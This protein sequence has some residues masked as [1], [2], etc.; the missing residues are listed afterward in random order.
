MDR[1]TL[2]RKKAFE[3]KG[4]DGFLVANDANM[5]Y[6]AGFPGAACLLMLGDDE[7]ILYVYGVNY[8]QAK[9]EGKGFHVE[10]V[11]RDENLMAKVAAR[12]KDCGV[13]KLAFDNLTVENYRALTKDL[14]GKAKLKPQGKLVWE[15]RK[16]K[17]AN[18]IEFMRKAGELTCEGMK[19]AQEVIRPGLREY[20][21]AA[22]IEYAM[23]RKGSWGTAFDT[24]VV[25]GARSAFPHGG[26]T[27]KEIREGDLVV[28]DIGASY[29][30]YRSDM[31]RT[32]VAGKPSEKQEKLYKIVE[33]AQQRATQIV[34][35]KA[36]ARYVDALA[37]KIIEEAGYGENFVHS[38]GHGI[39]LEVH[40][41]P[42]LSQQS[43]D[44]LAAGNVV[45]IEPGIYIVG[46]GGIRIEDTMLVKEEGVEKFTDGFYTI[47][48]GR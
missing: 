16:V 35:A 38:L 10:L 46:F 11:K 3:A 48:A 42:A 30:Y 9:A 7:N 29:H 43:R 44:R 5:L 25:S 4:F 39:G 33:T 41:P 15:L 24:I 22:E 34:K 47:E 37:R 6:F 13:R 14:R 2:L 18:E 40:E 12:V 31:T 19:V 20:E 32:F 45:T 8:E 26:C 23:R 21:V 17:D 1:I 27:D 28:V 36:R